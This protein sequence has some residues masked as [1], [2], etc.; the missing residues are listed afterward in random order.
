MMKIQKFI[1]SAA[2]ALTAFGVSVG[3]FEI[4]SYL[5]ADSAPEVKQEEEVR[6]LTVEELRFPQTETAPQISETVPADETEEYTKPEFSPEGNFYIL[7]D[8][9]KGFKD[10]EDLQIE[11][12]DYSKASEEN[13]WAYY[14]IPPQGFF[15]TTKKFHFKRIS[16]SEERLSFETEAIKGIS[17]KFVG[18]Y[19]SAEELEPDDYTFIKGILTKLK[20]GKK[21]AEAEVKFAIGGC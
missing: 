13:N 6:T 7:D 9:P 2:A 5:T 10:F 19:L 1:L 4:G 8:L 20:D 16:V 17:Y 12:A 15:Q 14:E 21:I 3:L 18:E 11:T